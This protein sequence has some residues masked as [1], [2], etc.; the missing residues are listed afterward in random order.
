M[1]LRSKNKRVEGVGI[2][3]ADYFVCTEGADGKRI[4]CPYYQTWVSM[5]KRCYS[6]KYHTRFPTYIGCAVCDDWLYFSNFKKWMEQQDW[7]GKQLDKDLLVG[8][9]KVYSPNTCLF[10][11]QR[12]NTT[13]TLRGKARGDYP[14]GT[15]YHKKNSVYLANC[16]DGSGKRLYLGYHKTPQ[17]AHR[18]WQL[19]KICVLGDIKDSSNTLLIKI[20]I[21][22][23]IDK[24]QYEYDNNLETIDFN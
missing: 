15:C 18:V 6:A 12:L 8:G 9:N 23:I 3:D 11:P 5:L 24:I 4:M 16:R 10:I 19:A 17:E 7:R 20:G 2:N 13:L 14:I 21:Q 22:R 1:K